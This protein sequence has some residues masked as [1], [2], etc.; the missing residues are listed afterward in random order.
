MLSEFNIIEVSDV[1]T[2]VGLLLVHGRNFGRIPF[3][4]PSPRSWVPT[5]VELRFAWRNSIVLTSDVV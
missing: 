4:P 5:G 1:H 2:K 3:L